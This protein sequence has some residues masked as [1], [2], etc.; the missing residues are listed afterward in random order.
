MGV[1]FFIQVEINLAQCW[2]SL[3]AF[4]SIEQLASLQTVATEISSIK[5]ASMRV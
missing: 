4:V 1:P 2:L 5:A 3:E